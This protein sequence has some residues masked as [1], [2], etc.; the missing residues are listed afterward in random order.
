MNIITVLMPV[1]RYTASN[2]AGREPDAAAANM[3][4][5]WREEN[6]DRIVKS[7]AWLASDLFIDDLN[8]A[9]IHYAPQEHA[10][11][12]QPSSLKKCKESVK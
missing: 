2:A 5:V 12:L 10:I 3:P 8:L 1:P 4:S 11:L 6:K 7:R 9:L